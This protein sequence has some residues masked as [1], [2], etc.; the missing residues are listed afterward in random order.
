MKTKIILPDTLC[1]NDAIKFVARRYGTTPADVLTRYL[2]QDGKMTGYDG[3]GYELAP[4]EI[5]LVRDLWERPA[6]VEI[7]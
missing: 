7:D 6:T 3:Y 2:V 4:N 1:Q 5:A